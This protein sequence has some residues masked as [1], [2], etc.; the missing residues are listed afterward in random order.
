[1][2][3]EQAHVTGLPT[4]YFEL[5]ELTCGLQKGEMIIIAGRP[6]M[7]KTSFAMNIAEHIGADNRFRSRYFRLK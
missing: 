2:T 3:R 4:G 7:G 1:M 5:D 6:S